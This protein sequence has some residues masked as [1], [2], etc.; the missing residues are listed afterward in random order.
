MDDREYSPQRATRVA[1]VASM[2][3]LLTLVGFF[4]G[5]GDASGAAS[6]A[7]TTVTTDPPTSTSA[8]STTSTTTST[9][10]TTTSTTVAPCTNT[11]T[12]QS[13]DYWLLLAQEADVAVADLY[14]LNRAGPDTALFAGASICLPDGATVVTVQP[15]TTSA[16]TSATAATTA[17]PVVTAAQT[18]RT[19]G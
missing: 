12:V 13:G 19:S 8:P 16:T 9:T 11:Y 18:T 1:A 10:S 2:G 17:A 4:A 15:A 7:T 14:S 5:G 6:S 3:T